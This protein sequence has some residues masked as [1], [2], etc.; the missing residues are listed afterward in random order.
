M[1]H[2]PTEMEVKILEAVVGTAGL[3]IQFPCS[4]IIV[5]Q[6]CCGVNTFALYSQEK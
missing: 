1:S 2:A 5:E 6:L 4:Y 3:G